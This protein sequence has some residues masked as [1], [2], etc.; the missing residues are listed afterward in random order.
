MFEVAR[1][2]VQA[3]VS[4]RTAKKAIDDLAIG[5]S[6]FV[7]AP[8][9]TQYTKFKKK[10]MSLNVAVAKIQR[11]KIDVKKLR[12][13]LGISQEAFAGRYG[14]DVRTVRNWEQGRT[15]PEGPGATLLQLIDRD[16]DKIVELLAS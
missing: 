7:A 5:N 3:G 16:P 11:R 15:T 8:N 1:L 9:V 13:R 14:L 2:L 4:V 6:T 10:M 12:A